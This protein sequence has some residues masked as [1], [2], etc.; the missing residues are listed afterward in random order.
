[1]LTTQTFQLK[2][3]FELSDVF[4]TWVIIQMN[5]SYVSINLELLVISQG[6]YMDLQDPVFLFP[7][8]S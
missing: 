8:Q 5:P 2:R 1:M 3:V 7:W 4:P 6:I